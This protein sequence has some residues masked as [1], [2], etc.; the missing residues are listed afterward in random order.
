MLHD[1]HIGNGCVFG[2]GSK[3]AGSCE[4]QDGVILSSNV[5]VN[6]KVRIGNS[7][8]IQSGCRCSKDVPPYIVAAHNP[9]KYAGVNTTIL[10]NLA[11][12]AKVQKHIANAYRLVFHEKTFFICLYCDFR[13][14]LLCIFEGTTAADENRACPYGTIAQLL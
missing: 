1:T 10:N 4:I 2:Y 6:P 12:D 13:S 3:I 14:V 5:V 11:V 7:S 9:I 8:M